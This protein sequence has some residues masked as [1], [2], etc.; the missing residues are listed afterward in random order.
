MKEYNFSIRYL[1]RPYFG[2]HFGRCHGDIV[3]PLV[4]RKSHSRIETF[5]SHAE[6]EGL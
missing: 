6:K 5:L 2:I 4:Q 1:N 3:T